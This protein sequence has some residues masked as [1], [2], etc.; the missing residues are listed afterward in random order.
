MYERWRSSGN[1]KFIDL[2]F[3]LVLSEM[4]ADLWVVDEYI[5]RSPSSTLKNLSRHR[6]SH[7]GGKCSANVFTCRSVRM[8]GFDL[9][10][11]ISTRG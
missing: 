6:A 2:L 11:R 8:M 4:T 1:L 5:L 3:F 7:W 10:L 9:G